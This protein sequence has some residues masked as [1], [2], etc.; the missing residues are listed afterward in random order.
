MKSAVRSTVLAMT[1][2]K[3]HFAFSGS[4]NLPNN[5]WNISGPFNTP[6]VGAAVTE[7]VGNSVYERRMIIRGEFILPGTGSDAEYIRIVV[8]R[9]NDN[10]ASAPTEG[11]LFHTT[12][13]GT[14]FKNLCHF[15]EN[16]NKRFSILRDICV[17]VTNYVTDAG[18]PVPWC[19]DLPLRKRLTYNAATPDSWGSLREGGI[20]IAMCSANGDA[21][22]G[23]NVLFRI[24]TVFMFK[25]P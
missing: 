13:V 11:D 9:D 10:P 15:N 12:G 14:N 5:D 19:I 24:N 2:T 23:N 3:Q 18:H 17:P 8:F 6:A 25:D 7:R 20:G 22:L 1:D 21:T 16:N 4:L